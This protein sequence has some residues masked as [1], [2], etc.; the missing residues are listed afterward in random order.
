MTTKV[1]PVMVSFFTYGW[2]Q[3]C[4]RCFQDWFPELKI[5]VVDN[6]PTSINQIENWNWHNSK[7]NANV[8]W[9]SLFPYVLA[10]REWLKQQDNVVLISG[11]YGNQHPN[12]GRS[13]SLGFKWC[14]ERDIEIALTLDPDCSFDSINWFYDLLKPIIVDDMW[15]VAHKAMKK[16]RNGGIWRQAAIPIMSRIDKIKWPLLERHVDGDLYS[17]MAWPYW[18]CG[19]KAVQVEVKDFKH[20][21]CGSYDV[22]RNNRHC[23]YV[24]FL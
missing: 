13:L 1:M 14:Q 9:K 6:N 12:H 24:S 8:R 16:P 2:T 18:Q 21:W 15:M 10:E 19:K 4:V 7:Y 17:C 22:V 23:P 20:H 11:N 3:Q 5:L